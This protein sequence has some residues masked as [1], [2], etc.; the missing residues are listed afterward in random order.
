MNFK[1]LWEM[2]IEKCYEYF[3]S[4][5]VDTWIKPIEVVGISNG[6]F[7]IAV[8]NRFYKSWFSENY[9]PI[10]K[11]ILK[12]I[13]GKE[14]EINYVIKKEPKRVEELRIEE[15]IEIDEQKKNH[16]YLNPKYTFE[17]FVVGPSNQLA[18]ASSIAV[19]ENPGKVYNPL[20]IY[21][22]VGLGKTHLLHAIGHRA[23][24][25][26][27]K[28]NLC[29]ISTERFMN[30]LIESIKNDKM[31]IFRK[32][33]RKLD[34]L[35]IDDIQFIAGKDRTQEEFFHTFNELYNEGKQIVIS[36]DRPP[37]EMNNIEDRLKSRFQ[38]GLIV[39]I[40]P[41]DLET[42]I[43]ILRKKAENENLNLS[44]EVA[45]MVAKR[46]KSNIR[47]LE[48][49]L[50]KIIAMASL[51]GREISLDLVKSILDSLY[52]QQDLNVS[53]ENI[54][55]EVAKKFGLKISEIRSKKRN[56]SIV[57]P[58]QL[59]MYLIRKLTPLSLPEIG[60]VFGGM[61]HTSVLHSIRKMENLLKTDSELLKIAKEIEEE[62]S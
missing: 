19:A 23:L 39:D 29:Y 7:S 5:T 12:E 14:L 24:E 3:P 18:H 25:K 38:W 2:V 62:F 57:I 51:T 47:E 1:E 11:N 44:Y 50:T 20:F 60:E 59:A 16:T 32:K 45:H 46:I 27:P 34:V 48:G 15:R 40:Q 17:N 4:V 33:Y 56:K 28:L 55:R 9:E 13:T 58:R 54:I 37:N 42:R 21:G 10:V 26:N 49:C 53:A 41:P 36:S 6:T 8:P 61:D 52:P 35:L 31:Q 22:G 43:A 30:E